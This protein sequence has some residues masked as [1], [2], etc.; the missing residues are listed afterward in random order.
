MRTHISKSLQTRSQAIRT[1]IEKCNAAR[2]KLPE[3]R[4]AELNAKQVLEYIFVAEFDLL[5]DSRCSVRDQPWARPAAREA[6]VAYF[7]LKRSR[8]ELLRVKVEMCRLQSY[9]CDANAHMY[10][11]IDKLTSSESGLA[12]QMRRRA[13]LQFAQNNVHLT[14]L[15][16]LRAKCTFTDKQ[17]I[18]EAAENPWAALH[19]MVRDKDNEADM[20]LDAD[21]DASEESDC[22][23]DEMHD[24][25][26]EAIDVLQAFST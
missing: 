7:K 20:G 12:V 9:I 26:D 19:I 8:E 10:C 22:S 11:I 25:A 21:G 23:E 3:P 17:K 13:Q 18:A 15:A 14:R 5:R 4:P 6:S 24:E 1:A 16:S 2:M